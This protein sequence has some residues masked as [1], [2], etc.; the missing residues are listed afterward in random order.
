MDEPALQVC[1]FDRSV[2]DLSG[3]SSGVPALDSWIR[4]GMLQQVDKGRL[5]VW[6]MTR[7]ASAVLG[8]YGLALHVV[9]CDAATGI[10]HRQRAPIP[11]ITLSL[12]STDVAVRGQG[13]GSALMADAVARV[14]RLSAGIGAAALVLDVW[15]NATAENHAA[16][17]ARLGFR[18]IEPG[19]RSQRLW[20]SMT[21]IGAAL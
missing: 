19:G 20:L 10:E 4:A 3:F 2:H 16:W 9:E 7:G 15:P 8:L 5:H 6:C 17:Y 12:L 18:P 11:A 14:H 21:D 1:E 13:L